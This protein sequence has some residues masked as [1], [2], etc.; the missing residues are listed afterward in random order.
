MVQADD[1]APAEVL[2]ISREPRLSD[3]DRRLLV[4]VLAVLCVAGLVAWRADVRARDRDEGSVAACRAAALRAD[5][6]ASNTVAYMVLEIDPVLWKVPSG[7]RRDGL[8]ALV[9]EAAARAVPGVRRALQLCRRTSVA[10]LH[11]KLSRKR[12]GYIDYLDARVHRLE[13][14]AADGNAY[15]QAQPRLAWLRDTAF[16]T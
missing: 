1:P 4:A 3:R 16:G 5:Q 2:E 11:R 15:Y 8:V 6:R 12:Q 13:E 10:W 14:V 9:A 7:P